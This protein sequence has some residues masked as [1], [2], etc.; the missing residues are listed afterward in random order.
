MKAILANKKVLP[1]K[2]HDIT[3]SNGMFLSYVSIKLD[4]S[5][6]KK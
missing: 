5:I 4:I 1:H 6:H 2:I 3:N